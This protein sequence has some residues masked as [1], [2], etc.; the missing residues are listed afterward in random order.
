MY[1]VRAVFGVEL[2][3]R[4]NL[5]AK[6][7]NSRNDRAVKKATAIPQKELPQPFSYAKHSQHSVLAESRQTSSREMLPFV[8]RL[9]SSPDLRFQQH[10]YGLLGFPQ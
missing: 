4:G 2:P 6:G 8:H 9:S 5:R 3:G 10:P 1:R 7:E